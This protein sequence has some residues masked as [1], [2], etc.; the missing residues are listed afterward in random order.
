VRPEPEKLLEK[1]ERLLWRNVPE[2]A[3]YRTASLVVQLL[4]HAVF[5]AVTLGGLLVLWELPQGSAELKLFLGAA[6]FAVTNTVFGYYCISQRRRLKREKKALHFVTDRRVGVI[7]S[8][9][10]LRQ[11]PLL[12]TIDI[13]FRRDYVE[14]RLPGQAPIIIHGLRPSETLLLKQVLANLLRRRVE[15]RGGT[16]ADLPKTEQSPD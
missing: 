4:G 14:F 10:D 5:S 1:G 7:G 8:F 9:G 13:H 6:A 16:E 12:G 3:P 15:D 11:M 2:Q